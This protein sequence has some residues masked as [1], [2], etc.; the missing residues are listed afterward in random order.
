[1][2]P[3]V[4][5]QRVSSAAVPWLFVGLL[6]LAV[7]FLYS[8]AAKL[9]FWSAGTEEFAA[10]DLPMSELALGATILLQ[11]GAGIALFGWQSSAAALASAAF[12]FAATFI[13]RFSWAFE[14]GEFQRQLTTALEHLAIF[15]GL[16][17]IAATWPG[18]F[19]FQPREHSS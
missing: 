19:S 5:D 7:I 14:G 4:S 16:I 11:L 10:S 17:V 9:V 1:M 12:T 18:R 6:C 15:G 3:I 13:G 2:T 8:G